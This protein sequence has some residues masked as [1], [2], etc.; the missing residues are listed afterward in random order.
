[1]VGDR[2]AAV[3]Y[4]C[5]PHLF[6]AWGNLHGEEGRVGRGPDCKQVGYDVG[7][8]VLEAVLDARAPEQLEVALDLRRQ[9][10]LLREYVHV[11]GADGRAPSWNQISERG[12]GSEEGSGH[13]MQAHCACA[14]MCTRAC[15]CALV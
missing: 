11:G 1:M 5:G 2:V 8:L 7:A 6:A 12:K 13:G 10:L 4:F 9:L 3:S 15:V 14:F